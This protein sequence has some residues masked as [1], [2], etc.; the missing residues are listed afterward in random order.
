LKEH[1]TF[2]ELFDNG[3][4]AINFAYYH[5]I[6][7]LSAVCLPS[8]SHPM[9]LALDSGI[10]DAAYWLTDVVAGLIV[11][12]QAISLVGLG[13][14]AENLSDPFGDERRDLNNLSVLHYI[15]FTWKT[16]TQMLLGKMLPPV[17]MTVEEKLCSERSLLEEPWSNGEMNAKNGSAH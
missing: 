7:F 10:G 5:F 4:Q 1:N 9:S 2:G 11:A 12:L 6:C 8:F 15:N 14:L 16:S 3:D 17:D 13:V